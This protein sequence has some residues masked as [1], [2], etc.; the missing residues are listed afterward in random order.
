ML[1][2]STFL[3][4]SLI[5][6]L[7]VVLG[8]KIYKD[9]NQNKNT[10]CGEAGSEGGESVTTTPTPTI[11]LPT[12]TGTPQFVSESIE[13]HYRYAAVASDAGPPC[14]TIGT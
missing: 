14:S 2:V 11:R 13:G 3:I 4:C 5:I 1:I 8:L 12:T 6:A 10:I 9:D 7:G